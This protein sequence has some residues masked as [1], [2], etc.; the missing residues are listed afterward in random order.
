M[1]FFNLLASFQVIVNVCRIFFRCILRHSFPARVFHLHFFCVLKWFGCE[2]LPY[3]NNYVQYANIEKTDI[4]IFFF[5]WK[6]FFFI[7][8][9]QRSQLFINRN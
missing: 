7:N 1:K 4:C 9:N 5:F 8:R 2:F 6:R 3:F